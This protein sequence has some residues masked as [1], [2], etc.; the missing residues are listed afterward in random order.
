MESVSVIDAL[1]IKDGKIISIDEKRR[2]FP[3][4]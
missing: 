1:E 3:K 4:K 2:R